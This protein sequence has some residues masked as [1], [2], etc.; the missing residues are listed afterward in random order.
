M[1]DELVLVRHGETEWSRTGRH[2]GRTDIALTDL[3]RLQADQLAEK[4]SDDG[5]ALV[6]SSTLQRARH[7]CERA[8]LTTPAEFSDDLLEWDYGEYEGIT[9]A[10]T[11]RQIP[12]W[13]VWTHPIL[14]GESVE[15]VGRRADAVITATQSVVGK[16]VLFAHGHFLRILA[17][18]WLGLSP[19]NGK[20]LS[21]DPAT[22]SL[23][24]FERENR[25]VKIWNEGCHLQD[26]RSA[27]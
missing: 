17:A 15:D 2:T 27:R 22:I 4:L 20:H 19:I 5:V 24:G 26:I 18:R 12:D 6:M 23:L 21:L 14:G 16:T 10:D 8:A 11:R 3:G 25:V 9:T 13:S 7:T 1:S